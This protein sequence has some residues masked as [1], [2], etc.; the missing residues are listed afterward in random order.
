MASPRVAG[1][2][3]LKTLS[4]HNQRLLITMHNSFWHTQFTPQE[5]ESHYSTFKG[6]IAY[7]GNKAGILCA[8]AVFEPEIKADPVL[9]AVVVLRFMMGERSSRVHDALR[10]FCE[11][12]YKHTKFTYN[13]VLCPYRN[14]GMA[15]NLLTV[16]TIAGMRMDMSLIVDCF[17]SECVHHGP[18]RVVMTVYQSF[19]RARVDEL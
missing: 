19:E 4:E 10:D 3:L 14:T 5:V 13:V 6:K 8:V 9:P 15:T 18:H 12:E 7:V 17:L 1:Y 2:R 16:P 11:Q